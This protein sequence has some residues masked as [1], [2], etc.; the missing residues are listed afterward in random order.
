MSLAELVNAFAGGR[1]FDLGW[2]VEYKRAD[3][4]RR[5]ADAGFIITQEACP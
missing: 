4:V 1:P 5:L 3:T 2:V